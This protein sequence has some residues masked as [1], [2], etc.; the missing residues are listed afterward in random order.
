MQDF[1]LLFAIENGEVV[2][3]EI[4]PGCAEMG[5][6][7]IWVHFGE[8]AAD[9]AFGGLIGK[10]LVVTFAL[11]CPDPAAIVGALGGWHRNGLAEERRRM[12]A[13]DSPLAIKARASAEI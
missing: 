6:V 5:P 2:S 10:Q 4:H 1:A 12:P 9:I 7:T 3:P 11:P 13:P 8:D